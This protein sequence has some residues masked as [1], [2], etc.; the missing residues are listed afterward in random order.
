MLNKIVKIIKNPKKVI[1]F[2]SSRGLIKYD[3]RKYLEYVY[4]EHMGKNLN[5]DNPKTFNEK[6]QWLK[7]NNRNTMYTK[8]VDKY[9]VREYVSKVIGSNY[10]I[11]LLGV[12]DSYKEIDFDKLPNQFVLKLTHDSGT[13][14]ICKDKTKLNRKQTISKLKKGLKRKYFY[15]YREWPYKDVKP[16]IIAEKYMKDNNSSVLNDYKFYCF[17]GEPKMMFIITE[18]GND[19]KI[20]FFD[21]DFN[22]INLHQGFKKGEK[23]LEKPK[24]FDEMIKLARKLS[25]GIPHVR[26]D[27]YIINGK[28]Y[29]GELTF[30]DSAGLEKFEPEK[31][32][33]IL[34]SYIDL[35][36]IK[37]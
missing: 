28:V 6:L 13:V 34:G 25:Y 19:P 32:D 9:E 5:L 1:I 11:P 20:N 16:R 14:I 18:R 37:K 3:D 30:F 23:K 2:L 10:L 35:N 22:E 15:L 26:V 33:E 7:L 36:K 31:Y 29:F 21:M 8:L 17:N 4:K 27:F 12:F 24:K